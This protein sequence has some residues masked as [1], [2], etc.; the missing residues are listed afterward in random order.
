MCASV[1]ALYLELNIVRE[2]KQSSGY[3]VV[4]FRNKHA[5]YEQEDSRASQWGTDTTPEAVS[6][7]LEEEKLDHAS[8][9]RVMYHQEISTIRHETEKNRLSGLAHIGQTFNS[10]LLAYDCWRLE[11]SF[12]GTG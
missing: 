11:N 10:I 1:R 4:E 7:S 2:P 9:G 8:F 6:S 5:C 12:W 3:L